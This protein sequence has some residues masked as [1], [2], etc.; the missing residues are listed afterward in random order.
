MYQ[1]LSLMI[2]LVFVLA[3]LI[4]INRVTFFII[5]NWLS[6][7][8]KNKLIIDLVVYLQNDKSLFNQNETDIDEQED[9]SNVNLDYYLNVIDCFKY[10]FINRYF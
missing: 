6:L 7:G 1:Y 8:N 4:L 2:C 3:S 9:C 5:L 10:F